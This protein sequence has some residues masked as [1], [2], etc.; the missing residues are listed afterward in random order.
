AISSASVPGR[1][2]WPIPCCKT[3]VLAAGTANVAAASGP[4]MTSKRGERL[5]VFLDEQEH[6]NPRT[7]TAQRRAQRAAR[8]CRAAR[9]LLR[10]RSLAGRPAQCR[11][12]RPE[13]RVDLVPGVPSPAGLLQRGRFPE[14]VS[15]VVGEAASGGCRAH[16]GRLQCSFEGQDRRH[17]L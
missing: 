15:V 9:Y 3:Q 2:H 13:E 10:C 17:A 1:D 12:I 11:R 7:G 6:K 16:L 5:N 4:A 14:W 8:A